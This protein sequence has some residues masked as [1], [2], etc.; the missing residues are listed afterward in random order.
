[1]LSNPL[2]IVGVLIIG[3]AICS[4]TPAGSHPAAVTSDIQ[5]VHERFVNEFMSAYWAI[6]P[7]AA[8]TAMP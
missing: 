1:M 4:T 2:R 3:A 8:S 5:D 6:H 7:T